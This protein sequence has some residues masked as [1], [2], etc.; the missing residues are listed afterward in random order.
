MVGWNF[1]LGIDYFFELQRR[2]RGDIVQVPKKYLIV[3]LQKGEKTC[4]EEFNRKGG[5][6]SK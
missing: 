4:K 5:D 1:E 6:P 3:T 2:L